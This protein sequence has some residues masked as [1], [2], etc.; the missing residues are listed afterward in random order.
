MKKIVITGGPCSGK[1]TVIEELSKRGYPVLRETAK[2]IVAARK[3]ISVTKEESDIRQELI[4]NEQSAKEDRAEKENYGIIFMDRGL[5]DGLGYSLLYAGE[6]S[7]QKYLPVVKNKHYD[8][9]FV[10]EPVPFDSGGFRS[11]NEN[12][13]ESKKIRDSICELYQRLGYNPISVPVMSVEER[14]EFILERI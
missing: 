5:I 11:E 12:E 10:F 4:F 1:T 13:E 9:I 7:I 2:E 8:A 6:E 3:N 14:V